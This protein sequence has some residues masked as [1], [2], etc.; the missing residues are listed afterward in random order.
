MKKLGSA[1]AHPLCLLF[2]PS[3]VVDDFH[4]LSFLEVETHRSSKKLQCGICKKTNGSVITCQSSK[5]H[6]AS[7][8]YCAIKTFNSEEGKGWKMV[9]K[10]LKGE[11][12]N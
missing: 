1:Y 10:V 6:N 8:L 5:C 2:C 7:H 11:R 9:T 3:V 4:S 12:T